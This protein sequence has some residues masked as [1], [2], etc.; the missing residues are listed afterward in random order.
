MADS[1]GRFIKGGDITPNE[2]T[3]KNLQQDSNYIVYCRYIGSYCY[4]NGPL[5]A[6]EVSTKKQI[7]PDAPKNLSVTDITTN[8]FTL[9]WESDDADGY[10]VYRYRPEKGAYEVFKDVTINSVVND[11]LSPAYSCAFRIKAYKIVDGKRVYSDYSPLFWALTPPDKVSGLSASEVTS[12]SITLSWNSANG[13]DSY[14]VYLV[15]G[16]ESYAFYEGAA[17]SCR[18]DGALPFTDY[19]FYVI[20]TVSERNNY[21]EG[22]PSEV[23][24]V[25]TKYTVIKEFSASDVTD[26]SYTVSWPEQYNAIGYNVYRLDDGIYNLIACVGDPFCEFNDL[27]NSAKN[28]YKVSVL[29]ELPEGVYEGEL[30]EEFSATTLPD[31]V[32]GVSGTAYDNKVELSWDAVKNADC[33][34]VYLQENG[35]YVLKKTVKV[36]YCT[37]EGLE[38][39]KMHNVRVRAYIRSTLGTQKGKI[40]TYSF[41]TKPET[42]TG[43]SATSV[44]DS[45]LT[46]SWNASSDS[47]N[48]YYV[49]RSDRSDGGFKLTKTTSATSYKVTGLESGKT[50]HF[51]VVPAVI[52]KDGSIFL[53]GSTSQTCTV[54]TLPSKPLNLRGENIT[55]DSFTLIWDEVQNATYYRVY[56]YDTSTKKYVLVGSVYD[57]QIPVSS[58]EGGKKYYYKV[59]PIKRENG[60]YTYGYYSDLF[61]VTTK[62]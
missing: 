46:L 31:N 29:Y 32:E 3:F 45:E 21:A 13:V 18:F 4:D 44:T 24:T 57:N 20:A 47:V 28:F 42:V 41:Y 27:E 40:T 19:S 5:K 43:I 17:N 50:C 34:N 8:G 11:D 15:D 51:R 58:L 49:Y 9:N 7:V 16:D 52:N 61:G 56:R 1:Q 39:A 60:V 62:K 10:R 37:L 55:S 26:D 23:L 35:K 14:T 54:S 6:F 48:R 22:V 38:G 36:N 25:K 2:Y 30:S 12:D 53:K 33:Y 59:R